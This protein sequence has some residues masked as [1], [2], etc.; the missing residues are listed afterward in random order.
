MLNILESYNVKVDTVDE[1]NYKR[2]AVKGYDYIFVYSVVESRSLN[3]RLI[4][5]LKSY[6]GKI[7]WIG[8]NIENLLK[9]RYTNLNRI[10]EKQNFVSV[11]YNGKTYDLEGEN[12]LEIIE[13]LDGN[14]EIKSTVS[15][16]SKDFSYILK[17]D[18][19][20][21]ISQFNIKSKP[22]YRVF[23]KYLT[24]VFGEE[25]Y[26]NEKTLKEEE[27]TEP[28][29]QEIEVEVYNKI[30]SKFTLY[31]AIL[32]LTVILV[33]GIILVI[34]RRRNRK[35]LFENKGE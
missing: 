11:K 4:E 27:K 23:S 31:L 12:S 8:K 2:Q 34:Y 30:S 10:G 18:N 1:Y 15:D 9:D 17:T 28:V 29:Y 35:R 32:V 3:P 22:L 33:F 19:L 16:G 24:E 14:T 13:S 26:L 7:V 21:F 25:Y 20:H 6:K 5:D